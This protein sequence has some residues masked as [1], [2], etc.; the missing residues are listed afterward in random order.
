[1]LAPALCPHLLP[2]PALGTAE[3]ACSGDPNPTRPIPLKLSSLTSPSQVDLRP[4]VPFGEDPHFLSGWCG[5]ASLTTLP[6]Q[7]PLSPLQAQNTCL[8]PMGISLSPVGCRT[9]L[10]GFESQLLHLLRILRK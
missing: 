3:L 9:R 6:G 4:Q 8:A 1:M 5:E 2:L 10:S 7:C